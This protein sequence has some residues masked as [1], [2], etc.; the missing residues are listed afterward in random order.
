LALLSGWPP[1]AAV[2]LSL[3]TDCA[4]PLAESPRFIG[5]A[6]GGVP[7][8]AG[9]WGMAGRDGAGV[10]GTVGDVGSAEVP[11]VGAASADWATSAATL[12]RVAI[13]RMNGLAA[14][15]VRPWRTA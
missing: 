6:A 2:L 4:A 14:V 8:G 10:T 13:P 12:A 1:G 3:A 11:S 5:P 15:T 9:A 7:P